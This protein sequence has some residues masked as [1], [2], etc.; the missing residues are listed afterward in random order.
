[1]RRGIR[2]W[3]NAVLHLR[4]QPRLGRRDEFRCA[5]SVVSGSRK[6]RDERCEK[7]HHESPSA[8]CPDRPDDAAADPHRAERMGMFGGVCGLDRCC[9][10]AYQFRGRACT[11]FLVARP[12]SDRAGTERIPRRGTQR[13]A[14][15]GDCR[16]LRA[17]EELS[18][19]YARG[20]SVCP[21][22]SWTGFSEA[23][24][25]G[26]LGSSSSHPNRCDAIRKPNPNATAIAVAGM[27]ERPNEARN[28]K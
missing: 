27:S 4:Q 11:E 9:P 23:C 17:A 7:C 6:R 18:A 13:A 14:A 22:A 16:S 1:M 12:T 21:R 25:A 15:F 10:R 20:W 26:S 8:A 5:R 3:N 2:C 19:R 24:D 28:T